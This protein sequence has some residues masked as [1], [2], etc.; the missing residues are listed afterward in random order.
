MTIDFIFPTFLWTFGSV[1]P[2]PMLVFLRTLL[3]PDFTSPPESLFPR[4]WS[5][6]FTSPLDSAEAFLIHPSPHLL[7]PLLIP[8]TNLL[9]S[10][11]LVLDVSPLCPFSC[12]GEVRSF[13]H[14]PE[15][16]SLILSLARFK[17]LEFPANQNRSWSLPPSSIH[18]SR[19]MT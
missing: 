5:T 14:L 12:G 10:F 1:P 19:S 2:F 9:S 6:S 4:P 3:A 8:H 16:L 11:V 13:L 17:R 15:P 7:C 18:F